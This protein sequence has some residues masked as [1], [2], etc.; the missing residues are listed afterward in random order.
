MVLADC[1]AGYFNG[2]WEMMEQKIRG[3]ISESRRLALLL[4]LSGGLMDAYTYIFRGGVFANAQT[5]NILLLGIHLAERNYHKALQFL[6]PVIAFAVGIVLSE[7]IRRICSG[8][9]V[10][11]WRQYTVLLE[12][13]LLFAVGFFPA[14]YNMA[15]NALVSLTCGIQVE[16]FRKVQGNASAT[17]MCIGNLR[18]G[19]QACCDFIFTKEK[20]YLRRGAIYFG[21][22]LAF[23]A[24]AVLGNF[25]IGYLAHKAI[26]GSCILLLFGFFLMF[27]REGERSVQN[28]A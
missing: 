7:C 10:L 6:F 1:R 4:A 22:I 5:G 14:E 15:A 9:G 28:A 16:S 26:W 13:V 21:I 25:L 3:Q 11:H 24:G 20:R 2:W 18:S 27:L 17:T 23:I 19:I 8:N 12:C